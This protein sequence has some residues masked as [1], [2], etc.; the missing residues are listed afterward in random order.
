MSATVDNK[1]A[2]TLEDELGAVPSPAF[3]AAFAALD[4]CTTMEL[5]YLKTKGILAIQR[6]RLVSVEVSLNGS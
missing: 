1:P 3:L 6:S 4:D 5:Y 2:R